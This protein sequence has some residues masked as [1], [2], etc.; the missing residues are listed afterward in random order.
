MRWNK[1]GLPERHQETEGLLLEK[2]PLILR[3]V[4]RLSPHVVAIGHPV[5]GM[6]HHQGPVVVG[7]LHHQGPEVVRWR[8][9]PGDAAHQ[10]QDGVVNVAILGLL[11]LLTARR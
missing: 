10:A 5:V 6:L 4:P 7:M 3:E 11:P 2:G 1:R 8:S 9:P